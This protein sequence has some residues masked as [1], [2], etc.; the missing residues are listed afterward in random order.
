MLASYFTWGYFYDTTHIFF[1][2]AYGFY[3]RVGLI[4]A[5][6]TKVRKTR[7]YPDAKKFTFTL[8]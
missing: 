3:F 6:K 4:I 7:N 5:E 1:I 8:S 2:K